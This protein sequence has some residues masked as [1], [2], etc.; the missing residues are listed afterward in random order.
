VYTNNVTS[1]VVD[2]YCMGRCVVVFLDPSILNF[3][4]LRGISEGVTF[5]SGAEGLAQALKKAITHE[6]VNFQE[7]DYFYIDANLRRWKK[8]LSIDAL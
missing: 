6:T 7:K 2:A 1:S 8:I 3:S 4:P 5:V